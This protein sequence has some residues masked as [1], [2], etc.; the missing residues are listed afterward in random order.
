MKKSSPF[1][2]F[3][4]LALVSG[5]LGA[6]CASLESVATFEEVTQITIAHLADSISKMENETRKR[7]ST[8]EEIISAGCFKPGEVQDAWG[9]SIAITRLPN[10]GFRLSSTGDPEAMKINPNI[11]Q[12]IFIDIF[13]SVTNGNHGH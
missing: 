6:F 5:L 9:N 10:N 4:A 1:V 8:R 13:P 2:S 11:R 12:K 3:G 7:F